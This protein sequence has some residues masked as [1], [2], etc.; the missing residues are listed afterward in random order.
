M[1]QLKN[2]IACEWPTIRCD[3][4]PVRH[5]RHEKK[6]LRESRVYSVPARRD[7]HLTIQLSKERDLSRSYLHWS[8][9]KA[10]GFILSDSSLL[11]LTIEVLP[12]AGEFINDGDQIG[13]GSSNTSSLY[14][15]YAF[16]SISSN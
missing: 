16:P 6:L 8:E 15:H 1:I 7:L 5:F 10:L 9:S 14:S 3:I 11:F 4:N 12:A 2:D 13:H